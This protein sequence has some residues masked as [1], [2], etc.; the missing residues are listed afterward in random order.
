MM[1]SR[2]LR[3]ALVVTMAMT[4]FAALW[5]DDAA[6]VARP[7][8]TS[9]RAVTGVG[10]DASATTSSSTDPARRSGWPSA[11]SAD[12]GADWPA[13]APSALAAW[14]PPSPPPPPSAPAPVVA[15]APPAAPAPPPAPPFPYTLIGR[16]EEGGQVQVLLSSPLR[17]ISARLNELV[18]GQWRLESIQPG[19]VV[20]VWVF[21]GQ[22]QTVNYRSS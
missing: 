20:F 21:G 7:T 3:W 2:N 6:T 17:T 19:G 1:L 8:L 15:A 11:P 14:Q 5:P 13:V 4:V 12:R 18:D 9:R 10:A 22:R 16:V